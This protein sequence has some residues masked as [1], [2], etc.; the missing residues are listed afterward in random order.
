[1]SRPTMTRLCV[2]RGSTP[3]RISNHKRSFSSSH[4]ILTSSSSSTS[5]PPLDPLATPSNPSS[6]TP[7]DPVSSSLPGRPDR[8]LGKVS[9]P[10]R[11]PTQ[12]PS[13]PPQRKYP[14]PLPLSL[15]QT[16]LLK[17]LSKTPA[18]RSRPSLI[19]DESCR[20]LVRAWGVDRMG[21]SGP[22]EGVTVI[23][24]YAGPGGL[25]KAFLELP[26][27]KR[28]ITIEDA[29]RYNPHLH[30]LKE[31]QEQKNP[32]RLQLIERDS[33]TWEAYS[34]A[35]KFLDQTPNMPWDLPHNQLF[36][37]GQIPN[38]RHGEQL[39]VQL[40]TQIASRMWL[41]TR[42][43]FSMGFVGSENYWK[44]IFAKPGEPAHHKLSVLLPS[45]AHLQYVHIMSD[46]RPVEAHFHKPRGDPAHVKAIK[47]TPRIEPLVK[48]YDSLDFI[49]KHMFVGKAMPWPKAVA[50]ITPGSANLIPILAKEHGMKNPD[51]P[52]NQLTLEEWIKIA[53]VFDDW[54][55]KPDTLLDTWTEGDAD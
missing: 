25:T 17:Q 53:N 15:P 29:F 34:E 51:K 52:V 27:V 30:A 42:G 32:G 24:T 26:N 37:A 1:M 50:A 23:D 7:L 44:K 54:P 39:F 28:V 45:I 16:E 11:P 14:K 20:E 48:N 4:S 5:A 47:V 40:V 22:D 9:R 3:W 43:R 18:I 41:F 55:F 31:E 6:T 33:F 35:A 19:S 10:L 8:Q 13:G 2:T 12:V 38:N 46:F 21:G 49:A 36:L